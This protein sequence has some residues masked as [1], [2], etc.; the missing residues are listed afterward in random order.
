M[1]LI[2]RGVT[3]Q[4]CAYN[5]NINFGPH[6]RRGWRG[7]RGRRGITV[8]TTTATTPT[9]KSTS[10]IGRQWQ[11]S[12]RSRSCTSFSPHSLGSIRQ[13]LKRSRLDKKLDNKLN[14]WDNQDGSLPSLS[15]LS[16]LSSSSPTI[17]SNRAY[18]NLSSLSGLS[19]LSNPSA[20]RL[21]SHP[22][23]QTSTQPPSRPIPPPS[24][25]SPRYTVLA[26]PPTSSLRYFSSTP[27]SSCSAIIP[28]SIMADR[29]ILP[30]TVVPSHYDLSIRSIQ[31]K[32]WSYEGTVK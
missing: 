32:N 4:L 19:S 29:D 15:A 27:K 23:P 20:T 26:F 3:P 30:S 31:S 1:N 10:T 6:I 18:S 24:S 21:Y 8:V 14:K 7:W 12:L 2:G 13:S 16:T 11:S 22:Q 5:V 25:S 28:S 17:P 9:T